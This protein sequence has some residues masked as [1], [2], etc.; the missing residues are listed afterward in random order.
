MG[1]A[2]PDSH[3]YLMSS[4]GRWEAG[5][6]PLP[7]PGIL[8]SASTSVAWK[9]SSGGLSVPLLAS[10]CLAPPPAPGLFQCPLALA[11]KSSTMVGVCCASWTVCGSPKVGSRAWLHSCINLI[12]Y[13]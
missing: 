7:L 6:H 12:R 9:L 4:R 10:P 8:V 3:H 11:P 1:L 2:L 5:L 13:S